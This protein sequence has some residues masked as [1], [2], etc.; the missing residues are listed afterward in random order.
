MYLY[1]KNK[2]PNPSDLKFGLNKAIGIDGAVSP[3]IAQP[4]TKAQMN[5][6]TVDYILNQLQTSAERA[7]A[8]P[9]IQ[10]GALSGNNK[11][12]GEISLS[13]QKSDVRYSLTARIFKWSEKAFWQKWYYL[14]KEHFHNGF[15]KKVIRIAGTFDKQWR[16]LTRENLIAEADPDI[17]VVSRVMMEGQRSKMLEKYSL[18][19]KELANDPTAD[20]RYALKFLGK[21][22]GLKS[23]EINK[24]LPKDPEELQAEME[25]KQINKGEL[26][27]IQRDDNHQMH[28]IIHQKANA[29]KEGVAHME[30]HWAAIMLKKEQPQLFPQAQTPGVNPGQVSPGQM[31]QANPV[32]MSAPTL[33]MNTNPQR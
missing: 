8:T 22:I 32:Q 29:T 16:T 5:M 3:M 10:Q 20:R 17:Y 28:L 14:Y 25:N 21:L 30:A 23:E 4:L 11:T 1:D 24:H 15:D 13:A 2:I 33:N 18:F 19:F 12:F 6:Q 26:P 31:G 9:E 27:Q 7:T